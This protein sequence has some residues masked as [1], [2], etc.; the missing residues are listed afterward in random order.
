[1]NI[2]HPQALGMPKKFD[3]WRP[4]QIEALRAL[5]RS[6]RRGVALSAPTGF[7]K[8][9]VMVGYALITGKPTCFVTQSRGLQDQLMKDFSPIGMVDIRGRQN[10]QCGMNPEYTCQEGYISNCPYRGLLTCPSVLAECRAAQSKL[11]VTNYDKWTASK[12]FGVGMEH[13]EQVVFDEGHEAPDAIARAMQITVSH[14]G[15]QEDLEAEYPL[16]VTSM[17]IWRSWAIQNKYVA[18]R[19]F[20]EAK[21]KVQSTSKPKPSWVRDMAHYRNMVRDLSTLACANPQHWIVEETPTGFQFDPIRPGRYAESTLLLD[22]PKI[23]VISATLRPKTM[24]MIGMGKDKFD[25]YEFDSEFDARR[26]PVYWV[27]TMRVDSRQPDLSALWIRLDQILARRRDR[28]GI[29]HTIS[30]ARRDEIVRRSR[31]A[32][33]FLINQRG[34]PP[35]AMVR[36]FKQSSAGTVLVSPSV[37]TGYDF[38]MGECEFQFLCKIPFPD[39]RSKIVK[40]RQEDDPEYGAYMAMQSMVQSFGRG[41]RSKGDQCENFIGDDHL[42]WFLPRYRHL[43]PRSFKQFF[44]KVH[45]LPQPPKAL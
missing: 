33:S 24:Y 13:F 3:K 36:D 26:C 32:D 41:M 5:L 20:N 34:E 23:I 44:Q 15:V 16:D 28:K 17:A 10:Y 9:P 29:I 30:Y 4:K 40:A 25:Y 11:V 14:K 37:G 43:A 27:P 6:N 31:F 42:A 18:I 7:G 19:L 2:P 35:T 38:P 45:T 1:M 22:I 39:S 12:G 8:S 21:A